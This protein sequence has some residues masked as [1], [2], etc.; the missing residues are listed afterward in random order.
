VARQTGKWSDESAVRM[1]PQGRHI[2]TW[3]KRVVVAL[4]IFFVVGQVV[5][6]PRTNPPVDPAR[7]IGAS[8]PLTPAVAAVFER[9]CN[10]CHSNRTVWLWYSGVAPASWLVVYD[11]HEGRSRM[12]FSEWDSHTPEQQKK[13]LD[14]MCS[15]V[16]KGEM[17]E[18]QYLLMH[19][20]AKLSPPE[21]QAVCNWA[22]T[23]GKTYTPK[24]GAN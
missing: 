10:D 1:D 5:R 16:T 22:E 14:R 18:W 12:N 2:L 20:Q 4:L 17:P 13:L 7:E 19:Q 3:V 11:V 21:V 15:D 24:N 8:I 9:S 6:L 23:A